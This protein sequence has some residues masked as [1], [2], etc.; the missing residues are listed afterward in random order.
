VSKHFCCEAMQQSV[1]E[2][3]LVPMIVVEHKPTIKMRVIGTAIEHP[4]AR[5]RA[6]HPMLKIN[7]CPFCGKE[8]KDEQA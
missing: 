3:Y 1:E 8:Q 4:G 2:K 6:K 7:Y 5:A